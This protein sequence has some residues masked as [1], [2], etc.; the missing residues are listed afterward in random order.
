MRKKVYKKV[1]E[2][3][4]IPQLNLFEVINQLKLNNTKFKSIKS[5][6]KLKKNPYI[7]R[8]KKGEFFL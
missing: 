3:T 4:Y 8:D 1:K 7:L 6:E 2:N 5:K